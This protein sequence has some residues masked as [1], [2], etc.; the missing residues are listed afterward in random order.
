[1]S[2]SLFSNPL[3]ICL[4]IILAVIGF[5]A[6]KQQGTAKDF[7]N[8]NLES[9]MRH[10]EELEEED[11]DDDED[12]DEGEDSEDEEDEDDEGDEDDDDSLLREIETAS[13]A[14]DLMA[15]VEEYYLDGEENSAFLRRILPF[16]SQLDQEDWAEIYESSQAETEL[17]RI[18]EERA[19]D[20]LS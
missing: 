17:E 6:I 7:R 19:G 16:A 13:S 8:S 18:A 15:I 2:D 5:M 3:G 1:M 4:L 12:G 14:E 9:R 20:T 10:P 11:D